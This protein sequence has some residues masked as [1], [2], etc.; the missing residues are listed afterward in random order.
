MRATASGCFLLINNLV[1]LGVGPSSTSAVAL[2]NGLPTP[3]VIKIRPSFNSV[4]VWFCRGS[5]IVPKL[6]KSPV[7]GS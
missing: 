6:V 4:A 1:G 3:P 2:T 5:V 7:P